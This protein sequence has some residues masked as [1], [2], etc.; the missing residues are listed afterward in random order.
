MTGLNAASQ[1]TMNEVSLI[2]MLCRASGVKY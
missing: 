1:V 2:E